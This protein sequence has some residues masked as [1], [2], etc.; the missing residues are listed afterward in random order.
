MGWVY[1]DYQQAF[2]TMNYEIIFS[3]L[4][5]YG[6]SQTCV[7]W[8]KSYL[9]GRSLCTKCNNDFISSPRTVSL[10]VPQG[11]TQEPLLFII[12]INNICHVV[13]PSMRLS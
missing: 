2:D 6:F 7:N 8:F 12:Y 13:C 10:G 4:A 9:M 11:S 3:K 1:I 5:I